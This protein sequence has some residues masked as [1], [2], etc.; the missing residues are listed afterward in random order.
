MIF[1]DSR[2]VTEKSIFKREKINIVNKAFYSKAHFGLLQIK[3]PYENTGRL[4]KSI[5]F[6]TFHIINIVT[7]YCYIFK[8]EPKLKQLI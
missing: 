5:P 2:F 4:V 1:G 7:V 6:F 8:F 3:R